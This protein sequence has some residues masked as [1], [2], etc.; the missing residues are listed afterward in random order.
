[1]RVLSVT[2]NGNS[3]ITRVKFTEDFL[4]TD[5]VVK[6]D[7]LKD[8]TYII[9]NQYQSVLVNSEPVKWSNKKT[10]EILRNWK[11]E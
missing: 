4:T 2:W 3:D 10:E 8:L 1:M 5:W 6:A 7:V 11:Y 9:E